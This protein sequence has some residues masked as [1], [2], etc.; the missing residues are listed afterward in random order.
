MIR[1]LSPVMCS[2]NGHSEDPTAFSRSSMCAE[3]ETMTTHTRQTFYVFEFTAARADT[4][5]L[6]ACSKSRGFDRVKMAEQ[7]KQPELFKAN[8]FSSPG[9]ASSSG[10]LSFGLASD[11]FNSSFSLAP[12]LTPGA[13]GSPSPPRKP[14]QLP[15]S[16]S[17]TLQTSS[18]TTNRRQDESPCLQ[19]PGLFSHLDSSSQDHAHFL[20]C[21]AHS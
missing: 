21:H 19:Q 16:L 2:S 8:L 1:A 20:V 5:P 13:H 15:T 9:A 14:G 11:S 6:C 17:Y 10:G 4:M 7:K 12:A 18:S 3:L